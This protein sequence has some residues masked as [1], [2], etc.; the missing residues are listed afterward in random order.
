MSGR[1]AFVYYI[2]NTLNGKLYIGVTLNLQSRWRRHLILARSK[3][4]KR[5]H[6]HQAIAKYG[7]EAFTFEAI[8]CATTWDDA[9][10][11]ETLLIKSLGTRQ[12]GYNR[13]N[14]GD[15]VA[16]LTWSDETRAKH[17][18]RT[19]YV[20]TEAVRAMQRL[21]M[22]GK[23]PTEAVIEAARAVNKGRKLSDATRAA[24]S[25]SR[26]G[27]ATPAAVREKLRL[28]NL[29]RKR[30]VATCEAN[31]A[32]H[33]GKKHTAAQSLA[34]SLRQTGRKIAP[35]TDARRAALSAA[36]KGQKRGPLSEAT[37]AAISA[38][39]KGRKVSAAT[40]A[41]LRTANLGKKRSQSVSVN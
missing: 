10:A 27:H 3:A 22:K 2:T 7:P 40:R 30:S 38:A 37:R 18:A 28:S 4:E 26:M 21:V 15:G 29:G 36:Q 17:A 5:Q 12:F 8:A 20:R 34:K 9:L 25:A 16:G 19:P 11:T 33:L 14:G 35:W 23:K 32:A 6:I 24:M 39:T 31:R 1:H 41:L 13:T